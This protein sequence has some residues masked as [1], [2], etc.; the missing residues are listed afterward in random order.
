MGY[1][2]KSSRDNW[3][4]PWGYD[5]DDMGHTKRRNEQRRNERRRQRRKE[6][7]ELIKSWKQEQES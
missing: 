1:K 2:S 5:A 6:K 4:G 3:N 7:Q